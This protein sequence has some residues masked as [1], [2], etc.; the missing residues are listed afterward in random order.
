VTWFKVDDG[1]VDHPK[2]LELSLAAVGLWTKCGSWSAKH[3]TDGR[4]PDALLRQWAAP[5]ELV[6]ELVGAGMWVATEGGYAFHDWAKHQPS[7]KQVEEKR[8]ATRERQSRW[9]NGVTNAV[10]NTSPVP[11]RP[12]QFSS[13][14]ENSTNPFLREASVRADAL[15]T[16]LRAGMDFMQAID[17]SGYWD[18]GTWRRE[19]ELIGGF[20]PEQRQLALATI[21][22]S[23]WCRANDVKPSHVVKYWSSYAR[24]REAVNQIV[25]RQAAGMAPVSSAEEFAADAAG[26]PGPWET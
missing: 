4:V 21:Q 7:R 17:P 9:R 6:A 24:G 13:L 14:E 18:V 3:L 10:S 12:D 1:F 16:A 23:E 5:P 8:A 19:L 15:V 26:R 11:S 22:R 25:T 20:P 2:V